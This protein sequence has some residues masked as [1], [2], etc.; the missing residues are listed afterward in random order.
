MTAD[1]IAISG[2]GI[3]CS[4]GTDRDAILSALL[5]GRTGIGAMHFLRSCH[6]ELP[7]G[8]VPLS[9]AVMKE[10]LSIPQSREVSRTALL[11]MMAV[12]D[13]AAGSLPDAAGRKNKRIVLV[14]GTTV[15]GMDIT[16]QKF[17]EM[18]RSGKGT[19]SLAH[20]ECGSNTADI[21]GYFGFFDDY[22][23]VSTACSSAA[24]AI[25]LGADMLRAGDADIVIAG[26]TE[27][28]SKFHLNGFNSLMIL[29]HA[30]CRPFDRSRSGLN[31]GEG[32]AY[33]VMERGS[34]AEGRKAHVLG[35]LTG[36]GNACDAFHQTASSP[37]GCG[38]R[39]AMQQA[40]SMAGLHPE[41]IDW[42][43]AHGTGTENNDASESA[44]IKTVFGADG[45]AVPP[46]S[47][48]KSFTGHTTSASGAI[49]AVIAL[50][51]MKNS[52]IPANI[53]WRE[54]FDGGLHPC[55]GLTGVKLH[56]IMCNSF[57]FGGNDSSL[58]ISDA[59]TDGRLTAA[60]ASEDD[61]IELA[62]VENAGTENLKAVSR[63]VKPIA[64]RRMGKLMK[65][66]L[67]TSLEAV[68]QS[69]AG[70][71]DAIVTATAWGCLE[72]SE[73]LLQQLEEGEDA[74]SP[75]LFM[76]STHNTLGGLIAINTGNHGYNVTL[77]QG[78]RS[79]EWAVRQAS[80]LLRLGRCR[81]VLVGC[82]DES[83]PLFNSFRRSA[84]M[85]AL[86]EVHSV[87]VVLALK[88]QKKHEAAKQ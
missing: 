64:A 14:S 7:V 32:A 83:T 45:H 11:G 41:D 35:W 31:L 80:L 40:L 20:H 69:G 27:A 54:P 44:A 39:L 60:V 37:D 52:F 8:E 82:H 55:M 48:T 88:E 2:A 29:D 66:T 79:Y 22:T 78:S 62:R 71:P 47:S 73:K 75:T 21:A 10:R 12:R 84:G 38:A 65:S 4:L 57:G 68:E 3:V 63:Y 56:N 43:H 28:L 33:I 25:I 16:E 67:L 58:I 5:S 30:L 87:A 53:G 81:T 74:L 18:M 42:I 26:G 61:I 49:S 70:M 72:N 85:G 50:L 6:T 15:A 86:P 13:A 76:Q 23:T 51:A 1:G 36:C 77:S 24:N 19:E 46:V 59:P 34:D 17:G 9:N